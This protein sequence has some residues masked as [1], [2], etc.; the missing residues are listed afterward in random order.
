[1]NLPIDDVVVAPAS[2]PPKA[3]ILNYPSPGERFAGAVDYL[4]EEAGI[5]G[6][7]MELAAPGRPLALGVRAGERELARGHAMLARP[8]IDE[9][10]GHRTECGF[11]IGWSRFD[12]AALED[13]AGEAPETPLE[14][15]L[16]ETGQLLPFWRH[17]VLVGQ[18][19]RLRTAFPNGDRQ[20]RYRELN[21]YL[22]IQDSGLFDSAWYETRHASQ[23]VPGLP[24]IL[25]YLRQG[26]AAGRRPNFYFDPAFYARAAGLPS[27]EGALLHFIR[28]GN[29]PAAAPGPHF[30]ARWYRSVHGELPGSAAL[31]HYLAH[32]DAHAPNEWFDRDHYG[33][34]SGAQDVADLY[35][36]FVT[37]GFPAGLTA[38]TLFEPKGKRPPSLP[39]GALLFLHALRNE[40]KRDAAAPA[41]P[42]ASAPAS[43]PKAPSPPSEK[44]PA[45]EPPPAE[46]TAEPVAAGPE[47]PPDAAAATESS[48]PVAEASPVDGTPPAAKVAPPAGETVRA[49]EVTLPAL[50][51]HRAGDTDGAI[52]AAVAYLTDTPSGAAAGAAKPLLTVAHGA[53]TA[54]RQ[55]DALRIYRLLHARG[56]HD[57]LALLRL[58]ERSVDARDAVAAAPLVEEFERRGRGAGNPW[59]A[60]AVTRFHLLRGDRA[61]ATAILTSIPV[62][63]A[64]DAQ[65]EAVVLHCL[66]EAG[67]LTEAASRSST[68][69]E[70]AAPTLFGARFRLAVRQVDATQVDQLLDD[71][72]AEGLPSWQLAEAMFLMSVPGQLPMAQQH[73]IMRRLNS[74][75]E[76][77]GFNDRSVVQ[78]RI[79]FLLQSQSWDEL[80]ALFE[81]IEAT[82]FARDRETLLRKLEYYCYADNPDGAERI[83]SENFQGTPLNKWESL[84]ILRLLS[85]LK[86]W[87]DA[88]QILVDHV[89]RGFDFSGAGH[90]A[91][92]V[93]RKKG[94]HQAVLDMHGKAEVASEAGLDA[95][96]TLVQ[97]DLAI[98]HS[99]KAL[100]PRPQ[101]LE[102]S[103]RSSRYRSNWVLSSG[104]EEDAEDE[105]C[106]FLCTN[107]RYFLSLLTFL[108]SF[109][110]QAPQAGGRVFVFLDRDV[111]RHWYGSVAMVAARFN[112]AV[113]LVPEAEFMSEGIEHRVEYGFFAGGSNLSR[114]AYFRLYAAR[115]LLDRH[116][117][118][119]AVYMD[120]DTICRAD[121]SGL[122][123][124]DIGD[125]L[126]SAAIEDYSIE[127]INAAARNNLDPLRYFNSG[128][129][130]LRMDAP[131]IGARIDEAIRIS[132]EEPERLVFHDQCA[133]NIVFQGAARPLPQRYNFFLRPSRERNGYI[134]DGAVLHFL[135]KPKPWDIMFDRNYREE[136]RVWALLLGSILPQGLYVDIFA[137][138]NRD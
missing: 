60:V 36:H 37:Q 56:W 21:D 87:E 99:A 79:H 74:L 124:L 80:G 9:V 115:W 23:L 121:L 135:D 61:R 44:K 91:M 15:Y 107:Q 59:A 38:S 75:I 66:M 106:M 64:I 22:E 122:F 100:S 113:E 52:A 30:D 98:V 8:D 117:Y 133:L 97:E 40:A 88:A 14:V 68:W 76:S 12:A 120:T 4:R 13:L 51:R 42:T 50:E 39:A 19:H 73:R 55:E 71:P 17:T 95:F 136:W 90:M 108:C 67:Q 132:E 57:E 82:P 86:R 6:W 35:E 70:D 103:R 105:Q 92:R 27:A 129:L 28:Q 53:F 89:A 54:R 46:A 48:P 24:P 47:T 126:I 110:G 116:S 93:V 109:F 69:P 112:R 78:A 20:P 85:E 96:I 119:R 62:F 2:L 81:S 128:V 26:E 77:R 83:Y 33:R 137:A 134:E 138:A 130:L 1:M 43:M 102:G 65:A 10:V 111:P 118:S 32:R 101:T 34:V 7:V 125:D 63:P 5:C 84:T 29:G 41:K 11:M 25:D 123:A 18:A 31:A 58:I 94:L 131:E 114:A 3:T 45:E 72:R 104:G 16:L 49:E 127:V